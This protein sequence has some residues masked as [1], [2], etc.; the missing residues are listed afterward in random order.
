MA[1][2]GLCRAG[3]LEAARGVS[4]RLHRVAERSSVECS[5]GVHSAQFVFGARGWEKCKPQL[6][7][8]DCGVQWLPSER[9]SS[10]RHLHCTCAH[11]PQ[12]VQVNQSVTLHA[13][14]PGAPMVSCSVP[15][16]CQF[17]DNMCVTPVLSCVCHSLTDC[18]VP[19]VA[20]CA[21]TSTLTRSCA[22]CAGS[23]QNVT[24]CVFGVL[25]SSQWT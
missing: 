3:A 12:Q 1:A 17:C 7:S 25:L 23:T 5:A 4:G 16:A 21:R 2:G 20:H 9:S 11:P 19:P 13:A 8:S 14:L 18:H 10:E 6:A 22:W 15:S 24:C